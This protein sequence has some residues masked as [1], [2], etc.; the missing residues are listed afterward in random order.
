LPRWL[1]R[2]GPNALV[3]VAWGMLNDM[4]RKTPP[5]EVTAALHHQMRDALADHDALLVVTP[6][7]TRASY[8]EGRQAEAR[9]VVQEL[10]VAC[11]LSHQPGSEVLIANVFGT[12]KTYL[13][14]HHLSYRALM[15]GRSHPNTAGHRLAGRL[16]AGLLREE[17]AQ[18][19]AWLIRLTAR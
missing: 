13:R 11:A 1:Y 5:A 14:V 12:M 2:L 10:A 7:A 17:F 18:H 19:P 4:R 3:V 6:A 8:Q 15:A 16:L 9:L